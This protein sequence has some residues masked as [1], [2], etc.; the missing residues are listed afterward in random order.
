MAQEFAAERPNRAPTHPG[1]ILRE[2]VL[3]ALAI[4]IKA[5]AE[6][7]KVSRQQVH[8]VLAAESDISP[9]MAIRLG[10]LCGNGA[11]VW[12]RMQ[13]AHSLWR[14]A[15]HIGADLDTIPTL[16]AKRAA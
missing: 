9:E 12:M 15:Q 6:H 1:T 16:H 2:D 7:L 10:K 4:T 5:L 14:A 3:P 13:A 8:R 11:Q